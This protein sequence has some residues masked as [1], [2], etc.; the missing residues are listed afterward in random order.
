MMTHA[1]ARFGCIKADTAKK[2]KDFVNE[3]KL[4]LRKNSVKMI[5]MNT[6]RTLTV[7]LAALLLLLQ[8]CRIDITANVAPRRGRYVDI[9]IIRLM[10][11]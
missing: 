8:G 7:C 11:S 10:P 5:Y 6:K 9:G 4:A 3:Y 2:K 1:P